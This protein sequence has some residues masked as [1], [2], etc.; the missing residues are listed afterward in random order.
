MEYD[1]QRV[2]N[3][4]NVRDEEHVQPDRTEDKRTGYGDKKLEGPDRPS[5]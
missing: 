5:T 3:N 2:S 4:V 1:K